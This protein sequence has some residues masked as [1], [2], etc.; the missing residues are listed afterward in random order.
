VVTDPSQEGVR[1]RRFDRELMVE[2]G[3]QGSAVLWRLLRDGER[4]RDEYRMRLPQLTSR[5]TWARLFER[6]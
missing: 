5:E 1:V 6:R 2:L 3:R 4:V